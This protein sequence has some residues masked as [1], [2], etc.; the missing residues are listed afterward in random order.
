MF[1]WQENKTVRNA[2]M[3]GK[4]SDQGIQKG[5]ERE[6]AKRKSDGLAE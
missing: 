5:G 3:K 2:G 4:R 1:P 6:R